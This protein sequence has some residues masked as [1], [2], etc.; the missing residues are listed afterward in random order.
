VA[1]PFWI[2]KS[3]LHGVKVLWL[4]ENLGGFGGAEANVLATASELARRGVQNTLVFRENTGIAEDPWPA[5][6]AGMHKV[7]GPEE[8]ARIARQISADCIWIHNWSDS[9]AFTPL[10]S[11]GIPA[12]RMVH[13]HALYCMRHYKY[14]PLTRRNCTRPASAACLFPCL[15][16]LQRGT[17]FPPLRFARLGTKLREIADNRLLDRLVVA[18]PFMRDELVKNGFSPSA[19]TIIAPVPPEPASGTPD[20]LPSA[21]PGRVLFVGQVIRGKGVD[22]LVR[23]MAGLKLPWHLVIAGRGSALEKVRDLA[24]RLGVADRI[25]WHGY[26]PPGQLSEEYARAQVVAV[27][28]AWQEP[29]G[30]VGVEAMRHS[31][32]V[33]AFAVGGIP[34]WLNHGEN[35]LLA[36]AGSVSS[37][38]KAL[39]TLLSDPDLCA[40]LG[41]AG[42]E[43]ASRDFSFQR[44]VDSVAEMLRELASLH[45]PPTQAAPTA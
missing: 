4:N 40:K 33:V 1:I 9:A 38:R 23:A 15:A 19:I 14:H 27:P 21:Q 32:P 42:R 34:A 29:F 41:C 20:A 28:S 31:R 24:W 11:T 17:G 8:P 37:L 39:A 25:T 35:G 45:P 44:S 13:D 6:F 3:I 16:F 12:A 26:L 43:T 22:L 18:S 30:M 36:A 2:P 5:A 10:R 7:S